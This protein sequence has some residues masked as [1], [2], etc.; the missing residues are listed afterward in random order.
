MPGCVRSV[1]GSGPWSLLPPWKR[2]HFLLLMYSAESS[3]SCAMLGL[4][5]QSTQSCCYDLRV[6]QLEGNYSSV[7]VSDLCKG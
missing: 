5:E 4:G 6:E 1:H 7:G 2:E 3:I